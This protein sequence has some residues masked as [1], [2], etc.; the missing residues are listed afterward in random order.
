V[1]G[2]LQCA[3]CAIFV[4][5]QR[6][7]MRSQGDAVPGH[8]LSCGR[9]TPQHQLED[10]GMRAREQAFSRFFARKAVRQRLGLVMLRQRTPHRFLQGQHDVGREQTVV[11][12]DRAPLLGKG[13]RKS[14][15]PRR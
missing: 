9:Q 11:H 3:A 2:A 5:R 10:V 14:L 4:G 6:D 1:E 15:R 7:P 13:L 12:D 8:N